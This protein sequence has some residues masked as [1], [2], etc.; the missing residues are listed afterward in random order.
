MGK[1]EK[2]NR[3]VSDRSCEQLG[4]LNV[5]NLRHLDFESVP[6]RPNHGDLE[7]K[8]N[9]HLTAK[10]SLASGTDLLLERVDDTVVRA[11]S[12]E[13]AHFFRPPQP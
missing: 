10:L 11:I 7:K 2:Q 6:L 4:K 3:H 1:I 8:C 13:S 12:N 5:R 9:I